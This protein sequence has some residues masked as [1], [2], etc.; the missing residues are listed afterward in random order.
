MKGEREPLNPVLGW[1]PEIN[2]PFLLALS[3]SEVVTANH[4]SGLWTPK[5][6]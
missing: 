6:R 4:I 1:C 3:Q 2:G 5:A